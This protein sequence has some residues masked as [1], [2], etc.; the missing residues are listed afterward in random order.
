[1]RRG[2]R[3]NLLVTRIVAMRRQI[4]LEPKVTCW[5]LDLREHP[6]RVRVG[7]LARRNG[8]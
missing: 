6:P 4:G 8:R 1:M 7:M 5:I 3:F 2:D